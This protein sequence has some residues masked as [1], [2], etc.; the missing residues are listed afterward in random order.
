MSPITSRASCN[1]K[2]TGLFGNFFQII[3]YSF[4]RAPF[5]LVFGI[6]FYHK[7]WYCGISSIFG[8]QVGM[9]AV[10]G[11]EA[12]GVGSRWRTGQEGPDDKRWSDNW[13]PVWPR[14]PPYMGGGGVGIL[15]GGPVLKNGWAHPRS[16]L[17][18]DWF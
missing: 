2:N 15:S 13:E 1:A 7:F 12:G 18:Q 9:V 6:A 16:G 4:L 14:L 3:P 5:N 10:G 8:I 17:Y 11:G